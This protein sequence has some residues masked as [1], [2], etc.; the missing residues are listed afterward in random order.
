MSRA[1]DVIARD[2]EEAGLASGKSLFATDVI[3]SYWMFSDLEPL[4]Q[5]AQ[6]YY[7][8]VPG[9]DDADYVMVPLCPVVQRVQSQ[10][11]DAVDELIEAGELE[12]TEI[13]RTELYVL[14][15]KSDLD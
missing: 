2:I 11:I 8:G 9:L 15:E 10:V 4:D 14:Y 13:R 7:G 5:G 6:W 1:I 3:T 12:L